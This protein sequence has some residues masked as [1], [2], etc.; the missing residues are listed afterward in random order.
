MLNAVYLFRHSDSNSHLLAEAAEQ[1]H[2]G[3]ACSLLSEPL[4]FVL[5]N[6]VS[7]Q[8]VKTNSMITGKAVDQSLLVWT[9]RRCPQVAQAAVAGAAGRGTEPAGV[10]H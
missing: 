5:G 3:V 6:F 4:T 9:L 2:T 1:R 8:C 7:G 10:L